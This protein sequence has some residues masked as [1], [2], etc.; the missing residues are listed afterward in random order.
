MTWSPLL[1]SALR[2][3]PNLHEFVIG[4]EHELDAVM[5]EIIR[6]S[7]QF[8]STLLACHRLKTISIGRIG[9]ET[10]ASLGN[11]ACSSPTLPQPESVLLFGARDRMSDT[12]LRVTPEDGLWRFLGHSHIR[13]HTRSL[14]LS[15]FDFNAFTPSDR[16]LDPFLFPSLANL[17]LSDCDLPLSWIAEDFPSIH[18][19][20]IFC[21]RAESSRPFP[22][23]AFPHLVH[24]T[25]HFDQLLTLKNSNAVSLKTLRLL[26]LYHNWGTSM[27]TDTSESFAVAR[28]L[29]NLK[30]LSF[31]QHPV[32]ALAWW[33]G[34]GEVLPPLRFLK[35]SLKATSTDQ[36]HLC[37]FE[38]PGTLATVPLEYVSLTIKGMAVW[39]PE[40]SNAITKPPEEAI[41]VSW[42][43]KIRTLQYMD[44]Q[45]QRSWPDPT[46]HF[47]MIEHEGDSVGIRAMKAHAGREIRES[48]DGVCK[49]GQSSLAT[50]S[51]WRLPC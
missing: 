48:Y 47:F 46:T 21:C 22:Q 18:T 3:M 43:G 32:R 10:S 34:F 9:T 30:C 1:T 33:N 44:V 16:L 12:P 4:D 35:V 20:T 36:T 13:N 51:S 49:H 8:I 38:V 24:L 7:P 15:N 50:V 19:L 5:E 2:L 40:D 25:T 11:A 31:F 27:E 17:E 26:R 29:S 28:A 14:K 37:C 42:A 39:R 6:S 41:A 45:C 23:V